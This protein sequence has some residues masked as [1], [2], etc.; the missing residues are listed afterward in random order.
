MENLDASDRKILIALQRDCTRS[1]D[2]LAE[3]A[4]LSRKAV[5]RF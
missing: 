1:L 4:A 5:W 2:E 3:I